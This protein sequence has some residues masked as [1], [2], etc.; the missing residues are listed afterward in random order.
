MHAVAAT[1]EH[2]ATPGPAAYAARRSGAR[3]WLS[4][5][6]APPAPPFAPLTAY[7]GGAA[8]LSDTYT[9]PPHPPAPPHHPGLVP[10]D[11]SL[12]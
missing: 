4:G 9:C 12:Q 11:A 10:G 1:D 6:D 5:T 7:E 3:A 2:V 8:G